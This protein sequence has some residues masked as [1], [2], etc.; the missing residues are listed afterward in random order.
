MT[1]ATILSLTAFASAIEQGSFRCEDGSDIPL[2]YID[3]DFCDCDDGSDEPRT[4]ACSNGRFY[5]RNKGHLGAYIYSSRVSDG[6]CDC[7]DGSDEASDACPDTCAQEAELYWKA[8]AKEMKKMEE[9][10]RLKKT[11]V[12]EA[13][14]K[15]NEMQSSLEDM[16]MT[17]SQLEKE[18]SEAE[19][20]Q[21][22]A[23]DAEKNG[24]E[25]RHEAA[26]ANMSTLLHLDDTTLDATLLDIV[27]TLATV[28]PEY[29]EIIRERSKEVWPLLTN[30]DKTKTGNSDEEI[31]GAKAVE[32]AVDSDQR[33]NDGQN[34]DNEDLD[35]HARIVMFLERGGESARREIASR[36][37]ID[38][39]ASASDMKMLLCKLAATNGG[40][41]ERIVNGGAKPAEGESSEGI[42]LSTSV[43]DL[44]RTLEDSFE[45]ADVKRARSETNRITRDISTKKKEITT[46]S[47]SLESDCW[48]PNSEWL[49]LK[50]V[51]VQKVVGEF[52]YKV[53]IGNDAKQGST[54]LGKFE[55]W[56]GD[57]FRTML[58][59]NGQKCWNGPKRSLRVHVECG[60][61]NIILSV[62]EPERCA[63][64]AHMESPAA[65]DLKYTQSRVFDLGDFENEEGNHLEL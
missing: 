57:D 37:S 22:D 3:D 23:E 13:K 10:A 16:K 24:R 50:D 17:L 63:Y 12:A 6:I 26:K 30:D 21:S 64:V 4:S 58:F 46:T 14:E 11:L 43:R 20:R 65:C 48:G 38:P 7:C 41:A 51:C 19:R 18:L 8:R 33:S 60:M 27:F 62:E 35:D 32:D 59:T 45:T 61:E 2:S 56:D 47:E 31:N 1:V 9:G 5:C 42:V 55:R 28:S 53:C 36:L 44:L 40:W 29:V 52:E 49:P 39:A 25:I 15:R 34:I 54:S